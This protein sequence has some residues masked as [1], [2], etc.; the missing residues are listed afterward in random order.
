MTSDIAS[1]SLPDG[2]RI[3]KL[4]QGTWEMGEI[5]RA[6]PLKSTRCVAASNSA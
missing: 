6:V 4:G 3:P 1:V 2:E 5:R